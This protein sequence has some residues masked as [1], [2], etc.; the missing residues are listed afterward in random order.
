MSDAFDD[1]AAMACPDGGWGYAPDQSAHLEPTCM[2]LLALSRQPQRF[3]A[4]IDAGRNALRQCAVGDGTY[5]LERGRPEAI[6]PTALVLFTQAALGDT[7]DS[8]QQTASA[9]LACKGRQAECK[10]E[11]ISDMDDRLIGWPWAEGNFSWV[12][13]TAWACLALRCIGQGEHPRVEEGLKLLRDRILEEGGVNYGNR[14]IFGISLEP[15][16]TPTALMLLALQ[17]RELE[18]GLAAS[19]EYLRSCSEIN[20]DLEHLCWARIALDVYADH[21]GVSETFVALGERIRAAHAERR[22]KPWLRSSPP[23]QALTALALDIERGNPFRLPSRDRKGAAIATAPLRSRLGKRPLVQRIKA[24]FQGLAVHALTQL[25]Q[26]ESQS[27]VHIAPVSDYNADLAD[28]LRRQ[29]EHF[30]TRVPL[31]GKRVV[32]KPNLVEYHRDKVINTNPNV[33]AAVIELCRREGAA[34]VLVAEGPGHWRNVE[35]LVAASGLGDV[36]RHHKTPFIDLN[37]DEPSKRLNLG[38]LTGLEHLYLSQTVAT[39]DVLISLPKLKTH[40]WA[41]AT[42]S[43]KNLFGTLP[44]ICYGWP[45]NELHWRGIDNSIVDIAATRTPDLAIVDGIVGMEGDGP[46]NG[47]A[48][49]MGVLVMGCDPVAVDATCCRLMQFDPQRVGYLVLARRKKLGQLAAAHIQQLGETIEQRA[50]PFDTVPHFQ[51]L[52]LSRA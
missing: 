50:Q 41:I 16:P 10:D 35:Y 45:K 8:L 39:A 1:L 23:R 9:L 12:E 40:H 47:T 18:T 51:S 5:R 38:R 22:E 32:L 20:A 7:E 15:I 52:R 21:P 46:L 14:R 19:V 49:E 37:H 26:I 48:K 25:R 36:L 11:E 27:N 43:L 30:R 17:G 29:Y 42:L 2:A 33:I 24:K 31:A 13:P 4:V 6:W 34:E 44:G 3:A 28:V